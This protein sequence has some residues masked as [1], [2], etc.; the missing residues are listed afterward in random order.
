MEGGEQQGRK[1]EAPGNT[2]SFNYL[3]VIQ[4][5]FPACLLCSGPSSS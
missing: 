3:L 5:A 1:E 4:E 2:F